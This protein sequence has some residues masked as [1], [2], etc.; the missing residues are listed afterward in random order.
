MKFHGGQPTTW[1]PQ[2]WELKAYPY[3]R[4]HIQLG[5][6][7]KSMSLEDLVVM[8]GLASE[9]GPCSR[10]APWNEVIQTY[11]TGNCPRWEGEGI[12]IGELRVLLQVDYSR[13]GG[14]ARRPLGLSP[15][16]CLL[17]GICVNCAAVRRF[18]RG[19]V[20]ESEAHGVDRLTDPAGPAG[21]VLHLRP[22]IWIV[23]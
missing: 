19:S 2:T 8:L 9:R 11:M 18:S 15:S 21:L 12:D 1:W 16:S 14:R 6:K 10:T 13:V 20:Q 7:G 3:L 5:P 22:A 17:A 4:T 23:Y